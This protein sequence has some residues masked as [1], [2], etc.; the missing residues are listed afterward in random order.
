MYKHFIP[1][2]LLPIFTLSSPNPLSN[3][4]INTIKPKNQGID[5]LKGRDKPAAIRPALP[6][7]KACLHLSPLVLLSLRTSI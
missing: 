2:H 6:T 1:L 5:E 4:S 7:I 3:S